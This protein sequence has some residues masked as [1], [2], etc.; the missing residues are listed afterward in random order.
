MQGDIK[1]ANK[2]INKST[3]P[4]RQVKSKN[5]RMV[6]KTATKLRER[7]EKGCNSVPGLVMLFSLESMT[8]TN[9]RKKAINKQTNKQKTKKLTALTYPALLS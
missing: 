1:P 5:Q 9:E 3:K 4:I 2:H 8:Q 6:S 7:K